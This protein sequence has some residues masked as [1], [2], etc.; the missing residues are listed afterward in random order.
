[1]V[2]T[3]TSLFGPKRMKFW[4]MLWHE[5][6]L[7]TFML[8]KTDTKGHVS[9]H[10]YEVTKIVK[11]T[12]I[13]S[14][15]KWWLPEAREKGKW[16]NNEWQEFQFGTEEWLMVDATFTNVHVTTTWRPLTALSCTLLNGLR[17]YMLCMLYHDK[18]IKIKNL[19]FLRHL[20]ITLR[21]WRWWKGTI[22]MF[23]A[24]H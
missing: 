23:L 22:A 13:E 19:V 10:V 8:S 12:V 18:K 14:R 3:Y 6:P 7:Q 1:M 15:M 9:F 5:W 11:F 16:V 20:S 17:Q 4:Y 2:Y 21:L 24:Q